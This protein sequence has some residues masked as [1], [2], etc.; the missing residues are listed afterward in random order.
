[1]STYLQDSL[2]GTGLLSAHTTTTPPGGAWLTATN[3]TLDAGGVYNNTTSPTIAVSGMPMPS[4]PN[5]QLLFSM[6]NYNSLSGSTCGFLCLANGTNSYG[7][8][9]LVGSTQIIYNGG[10][11]SSYQSGVPSGTTWKFILTSQVAGSTINL[12]VSYSAPPYT[13]WSG[14]SSWTV[15]SSTGWTPDLQI[16]C[17]GTVP[18]AGTGFRLS[19]LTLQDIQPLA[20]D[21]DALR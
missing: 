19:N 4:T 13:S 10:R 2:I 1:M 14:L 5:F 17:Y 15:P 9:A 20:T 11:T 21:L 8:I 16:Y 7:F 3:W 6:T 18:S 12:T